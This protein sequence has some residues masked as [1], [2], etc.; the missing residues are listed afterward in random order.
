MTQE[1]YYYQPHLES[2]HSYV[3]QRKY[4]EIPK[5]ILRR[6]ST[7]NTE[8]AESGNKVR[9]KLSYAASATEGVAASTVQKPL[10]NHE[11]FKISVFCTASEKANYGLKM[12]C[13]RVFYTR[14][15]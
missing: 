11:K 12:S 3:P 13:F 1:S 10:L 8:L 5:G 7:T 6:T 15:L 4:D 14:R 9:R 2:R